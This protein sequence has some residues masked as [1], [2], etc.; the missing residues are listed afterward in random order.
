MLNKNMSGKR[1]AFWLLEI[2][3]KQKPPQNNL[4]KTK[5]RRETSA[6]TKNHRK[7]T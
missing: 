5:D 2:A 7:P 3:K 1:E 4:K 6:K